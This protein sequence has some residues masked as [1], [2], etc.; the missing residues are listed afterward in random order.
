MPIFGGGIH[1]IFSGGFYSAGCI[2]MISVV[3]MLC[4]EDT[5]RKS[6][7]TYVSFGAISASVILLML[8]MLSPSL[9]RTELSRSARIELILS[10]GRTPQMLQLFMVVLWFGNLLHL[11]NAECCSAA[12]YLLKTAPKAGKRAISA[13]ITLA[14]FLIA[15][16]GMCER[17]QISRLYKGA[18]Y[19]MIGALMMCLLIISIFT[20]WRQEHA[21]RT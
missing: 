5:C 13:F 17:G 20:N 16:T 2:S 10:N 1:E 11:L 8:G 3:W 7:I 12:E 4:T 21:K 19:P 18:L 6:L 9:V 14:V 15:S